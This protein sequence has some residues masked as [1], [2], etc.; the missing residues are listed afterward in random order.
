MEL[1]APVAE[2]RILL[3]R[4]ILNPDRVRNLFSAKWEKENYDAC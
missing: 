2:T 3:F 1:E 4:C